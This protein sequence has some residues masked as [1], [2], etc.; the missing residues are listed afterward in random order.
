M[1]ILVAAGV[2]GALH[3]GKV[4]PALPFLRADL[5]VSGLTAAWVL[6]IFA[7]MGA[8]VSVPFGAFADRIGHRRI[9][10][11]AMAGIAAAS[12]AGAASANV[13]ELLIARVVEGFGFL[14]MAVAIPPLIALRTRPHDRRVALG[15]WSAYMPIGVATSFFVSPFVL[16][17]VGWRGVWLADAFLAALAAAAVAAFVAPSPRRA[18]AAARFGAGV[19][20][21][22]AARSPFY[23]G[24]AFGAYAASYFAIAG[25][26]PVILLAAGAGVAVAGGISAV[27]ALING[28]GN[29]AGSIA[30]RRVPR[31]TIMIAGASVLGAG[32]AAFYLTGLPLWLRVAC[33]TIALLFGG[34]V[35]GIVAGTLTTISPAPSLNG[36]TQGVLQQCSSIGQ[37]V[38]PPAIALAA[39]ERGGTSG[40]FVV[41]ALAAIGIA[42]ATLLERSVR[43]RAPAA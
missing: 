17:S 42:A 7:A 21:V 40:A 9:V 29:L 16:G 11:G 34:M 22:I 41:L 14:A 3:V 20:T 25:F 13:A 27:A 37:L 28:F 23:A 10:I 43:A 19:R 35:P 36:T 38:G 24:V 39:A 26:M 31:A 33:V 30:A 4:P 5:G 8:A 32:G 1:A 6:S 15:L 2:V 12:A 18:P